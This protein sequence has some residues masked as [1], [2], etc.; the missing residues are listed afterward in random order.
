MRLAAAGEGLFPVD[1]LAGQAAVQNE[2]AA[3]GVPAVPAEWVADPQWV[4]E[5][6]VAMARVAGHAVPRMWPVRGWLAGTDAPT[7]TRAVEGFVTTVAALHRTTADRPD[8]ES[9]RGDGRPVVGVPR[10]GGGD[11]VRARVPHGRARLVR[12]Q[13]A[14]RAPRRGAA[15]G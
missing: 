9:L 8:A 15:L 14:G 12:P 3:L 1:D 10:L 6:F 2:V 4:G 5:P 7:R 11:A 13:P